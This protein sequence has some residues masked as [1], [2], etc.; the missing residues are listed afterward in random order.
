MSAQ[1]GWTLSDHANSPKSLDQITSSKWDYVVLQEQSEIPAIMPSRGVS[2]YPAARMLV[3]LIK[4]TGATP[5]FFITWGHKDGLPE[6]GIKDYQSMQIQI[7]NGYM[8]I[9][10]ELSV[11]L[12]PV[13]YAWLL[14]TI[15]NSKLDLWQQDGSH[16]TEI[17]TYLAACVFYAVIFR[18]PPLGLSF[19][20]QL[21]NETAQLLQQVA[22]HTVLE[23][24][25]Q[26]NLP[27][28]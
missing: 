13:G 15:Q 1:G 18:E 12:A 20:G 2:M 8:E 14:A 28:P 22:S 4:S 9:A 3:R 6:Y 23:D 11:P 17:G 24:I 27:N 25:E 21:G 26:W 19:K 5:I 7:D 10:K 16:P